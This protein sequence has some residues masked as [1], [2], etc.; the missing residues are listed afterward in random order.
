MSDDLDFRI[1]SR[2]NA[3]RKF[4]FMT[5]D[6]FIPALVIFLV[7][8]FMFKQPIMA[9]ILARIWVSILK[10]FKQGHGTDF[11][12][13]RLQRILPVSVFSK[14]PPKSKNKSLF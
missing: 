2:L 5:L 1:P 12:M 14:V 8:F 9:L 3:P 10:Y 6:E 13:I 4:L 7:V 11:L